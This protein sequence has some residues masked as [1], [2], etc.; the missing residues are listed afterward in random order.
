MRLSSLALKNF[1]CFTD[2]RIYFDTYTA[3]VGANNAGKSALIGAL[4]I[5]FRSNPKNIPVT[6]DDFFKRDVER[7][8]EIT[9]TFADLTEDAVREFEHYVSSDE[10]TFL[11]KARIE[12]G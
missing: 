3:L 7:E 8:L 5:F 9:L 2:E 12:N 6:I 1:R 10:L 4:D 11:I